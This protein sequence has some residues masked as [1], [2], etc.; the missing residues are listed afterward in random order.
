M[1]IGRLLA[2]DVCSLN[3]LNICFCLVQASNVTIVQEDLFLQSNNG[4]N[5]YKFKESHALESA[6]KIL[7]KFEIR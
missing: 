3:C 5:E 2:R 1:V 4:S 6:I 7:K